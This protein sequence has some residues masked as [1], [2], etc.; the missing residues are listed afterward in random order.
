[1]FS[2]GNEIVS[3]HE[4]TNHYPNEWV[5]IEIEQTDEDGFATAGELITHSCD[6]RFVWS[7]IKLKE[8]FEQV[9][10]FYTGSKRLLQNAA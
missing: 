5:A 2:R 6:E 7:A 1:M 10:V 4:I 8:S 3:L 9:Y